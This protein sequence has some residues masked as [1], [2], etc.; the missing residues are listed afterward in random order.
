MFWWV[1][2]K[3]SSIK[4][5]NHSDDLKVAFL[6]QSNRN[7]IRRITS[8]SNRIDVRRWKFQNI[9]LMSAAIVAWYSRVTCVDSAQLI[10]YYF[11][12]SALDVHFFLSLFLSFF[13]CLSVCLSVC[14]SFL[15]G[16]SIRKS[17]GSRW[18][19]PPFLP[20]AIFSAFLFDIHS[21]SRQRALINS[22]SSRL[23]FHVYYT[24]SD[25]F[26]FRCGR[27]TWLISNEVLI[28]LLININWKIRRFW[29]HEIS[30]AIATFSS[31]DSAANAEAAGDFHRTFTT[32]LNEEN[33]V[34]NWLIR[35]DWDRFFIQSEENCVVFCWF[36]TY[37]GVL[38]LSSRLRLL[39]YWSKI[40]LKIERMSCNF[41]KFSAEVSLDFPSNSIV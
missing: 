20:A 24:S 8:K 4:W 1:N 5:M 30:T 16:R 35:I 39:R 3:S 18:Y 25:L 23:F 10:W 13:L 41:F 29:S 21:V 32:C 40:A 37:W 36:L 6:A 17:A 34:Q 22:L 7:D 2:S 28:T 11:L 15:L 9:Y 38:M 19:L 14:V 33:S 12:L 27:L 26:I 31:A